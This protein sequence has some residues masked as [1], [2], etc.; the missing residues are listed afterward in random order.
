[1]NCVISGSKNPTNLPYYTHD[2][3]GTFFL[4]HQ[5]HSQDQEEV[6]MDVKEP[7]LDSY[8]LYELIFKGDCNKTG[9][10]ANMLLKSPVGKFS[11]CKFVHCTNNIV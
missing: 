2:E 4:S 3:L 11:P 9:N 6:L 10:R 5:N 1:M 7:P 8:G